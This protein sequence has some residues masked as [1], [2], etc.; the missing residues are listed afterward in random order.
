MFTASDGT[1]FVDRRAY[2]K[3][4]FELSYTFRKQSGAP[5]EPLVLAKEPGSID[6]QPFE[7]EDLTACEVLLLD[8]SEAVQADQLEDCR[9]LIAASCDSVFIRNCR[10]CTFTVACKQL[11]TRECED[12]T[13]YLLSNTEPVIELS[14]GLRFAPF[15]AEYEELGT[16]V[17]CSS[18]TIKQQTSLCSIKT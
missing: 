17:P 3:Y 5:G 9:V 1:T 4:E 18:G 14:S 7:L 10:G 2:R 16:Q 15:N 11:R 13:F 12:C 8:H 6:G